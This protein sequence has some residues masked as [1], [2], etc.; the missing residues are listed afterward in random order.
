MS[1]LLHRIMCYPSFQKTAV[2]TF[3]KHIYIGAWLMHVSSVLL[4]QHR[5]LL[6]PSP[7]Q[8]DLLVHDAVRGSRLCII[9]DVMRTDS[10]GRTPSTQTFN[11]IWLSSSCLPLV[12]QPARSTV[13]CL[14]DG[15]LGD[16][17]TLQKVTSSALTVLTRS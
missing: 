14:G 17:G 3:H 15:A 11:K 7:A 2:D 4:S 12:T 9:P 5:A 1:K 8:A 10:D 6:Y 13:M 16:A